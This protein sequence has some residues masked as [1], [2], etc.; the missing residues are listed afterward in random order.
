MYFTPHVSNSIH[1]TMTVS[2]KFE[3]KLNRQ[4]CF[5]KAIRFFKSLFQSTISLHIMYNHASISISLTW[6]CT[7]H[8]SR[9]KFTKINSIKL[10]HPNSLSPQ[11][12]LNQP[13]KEKFDWRFDWQRHFVK[14][15]KFL[16]EANIINNMY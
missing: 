5:Q 3:V 2:L 7:F 14:N 8:I 4:I 16:K 15:K 6:C 13:P 12:P 9:K 10:T 11:H 1:K